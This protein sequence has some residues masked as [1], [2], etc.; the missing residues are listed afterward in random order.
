MKPIRHLPLLQEMRSA[1]GEAAPEA[2]KRTPAVIPIPAALGRGH[3]LLAEDNIVNQKVC[4][5]ILKRL[6]YSCDFAG[7][8]R[9]VLKALEKTEYAAIL[10]DCQMPEMDGLEAARHI[11]DRERMDPAGSRRIP[12]I[13]LTANVMTGERERCIAAGMD[14]YLPKPL[15][16]EALEEKLRI[17]VVRRK[18][19]N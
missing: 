3:V 9:E 19:G 14:D 18:S 8:G 13:A 11:R 6:G 5:L 7:T 10:L 2:A 16:P 4:T 15:R 17:W 1:L 12:I